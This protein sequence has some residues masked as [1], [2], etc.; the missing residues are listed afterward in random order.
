MVPHP[1]LQWLHKNI[2]WSL[3]GVADFSNYQRTL[4]DD[5]VYFTLIKRSGGG[6]VHCISPAV[7]FATTLP[8]S[9]YFKKRG[10]EKERERNFTEKEKR[11]QQSRSPVRFCSSVPLLLCLTL[12]VTIAAG[13]AMQTCSKRSEVRQ[14]TGWPGQK[15]TLSLSGQGN[16]QAHGNSS[17]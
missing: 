5:A 7:W 4:G 3:S 12:V 10:S 13:S 6:G 1:Q 17:L 16:T 11:A 8:Y 14:V 15:F 2:L 9:P